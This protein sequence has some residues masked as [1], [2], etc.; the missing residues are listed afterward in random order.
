ML[1]VSQNVCSIT[2]RECNMSMSAVFRGF[3]TSSSIGRRHRAGTDNMRM[4]TR[5]KHPG[6]TQRTPA[7]ISCGQTRVAPA[8]S[9]NGQKDS[10]EELVALS[11]VLIL[12]I[13]KA[14][15]GSEDLLGED[16]PTRICQ[17]GPAVRTYSGNQRM[18]SKI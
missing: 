2:R 13:H 3:T 8:S 6:K 5:F 1:P 17:R 15:P 16:S 12:H 10:R 7:A 18:R 11:H 14:R 4:Y 9:R